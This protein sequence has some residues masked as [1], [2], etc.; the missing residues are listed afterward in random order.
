VGLATIALVQAG[1]APTASAAPFAYMAN[2]SSGTVSVVDAVNPEAPQ[3]VASITVGSMPADV[4]VNAAGTRAYVPNW[5][6]NTL[7]VIDTAS[8]SVVATVNVGI[9]PNAVA[10]HPSGSPVYVAN[11]GGTISVVD[12]S[13]FSVTEWTGFGNL[14]G[15]AVNRA[16]TRLYVTDANAPH[17]G[18]SGSVYALDLTATSAPVQIPIGD[19]PMGIAVNGLGTRVYAAGTDP[20]TGN[21]VVYVINTS[22]NALESAID[23]G[24]RPVGVAVNP[25]GSLVYVANELDGSVSVIYARLNEVIETVQ[26]SGQPHGVALDSNGANVFIGAAPFNNTTGRVAVLNAS[27]NTLIGQVSVGRGPASIGAFVGNGPAPSG[28]SGDDVAALQK[29]LDAANKQIQELTTQLET[30]QA[31][32][33]KLQGLL[34]TANAKIEQLLAEYQNSDETLLSFLE[35]VMTGRTDLVVASAARD[36]AAKEIEKATARF[37]AK[38]W[39]VKHAKKEFN[40]GLG[41]MA[42]KQYAKAVKDFREAYDVCWR[43]RRW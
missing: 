14:M 22:T 31:A 12:A 13:T 42:E 24:T 30:L 38:D 15:I 18:G 43:A 26:L 2:M 36:A 32:N 34:D 41:Y 33:L 3:V 40:H 6:D 23:V 11:S 37:G 5:N 25:A 7:S 28:P 19:A 20:F 27:S 4:A 1:A 21:G 9:M 8:H 39:R 10:V 16:G 29:L 17:A 35:R